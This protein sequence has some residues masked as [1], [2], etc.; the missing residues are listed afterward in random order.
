MFSAEEQVHEEVAERRRSL[1]RVGGGGG[2]PGRTVCG[3]RTSAASCDAGS[4]NGGSCSHKVAGIYGIFSRRLILTQEE[5]FME[6][7]V[8]V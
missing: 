4:L 1:Q 8:F 3:F 2:L 5:I 6:T 7:G